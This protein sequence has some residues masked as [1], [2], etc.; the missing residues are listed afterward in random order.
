MGNS[1]FAP[2]SVKLC[3]GQFRCAP[4]RHEEQEMYRHMHFSF[5]AEIIWDAWV[6]QVQ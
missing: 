4:K 5:V 1:R 3:N 2:S 6:A